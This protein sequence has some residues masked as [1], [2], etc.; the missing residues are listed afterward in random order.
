VFNAHVAQMKRFHPGPNVMVQDEMRLTDVDVEG[1]LSAS[2]NAP[3]APDV[4]TRPKRDRK[5][6]DFFRA[7]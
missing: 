6:P 7:G 2:L 1:D 3:L 4:T 5:P